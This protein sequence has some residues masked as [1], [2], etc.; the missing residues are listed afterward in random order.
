MASKFFHH[1]WFSAATLALAALPA[2]AD[3]PQPITITTAIVFSAPP[4]GTFTATGPICAS[5]TFVDEFIAG[6]GGFR[7]PRPAA[8]ALT[9]RKHLTCADG[10]GTLTIQFHPQFNPSSPLTFDESGPW[11]I[12]GRGTGQYENLEGHGDFGVIYQNTEPVTATE[13]FAGFVQLN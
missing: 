8:Y 4:Q 7:A 5:G 9:V 13:T 6:G 12:F 2:Q 1:R 3:S 11:T 10:S